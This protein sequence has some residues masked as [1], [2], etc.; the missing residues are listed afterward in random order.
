MLF[1]NVAIKLIG[2]GCSLRPMLKSSLSKFW[3]RFHHYFLFI[4]ALLNV[5]CDGQHMGYHF[6]SCSLSYKNT[7]RNPVHLHCRV[8]ALL[9]ACNFRLTRGLVSGKLAISDYCYIWS[10]KS[11]LAHHHS[12]EWNFRKRIYSVG[13]NLV[14]V[15]SI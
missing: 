9:T 5:H 2:I 14:I 13:Y 10:L 15:K 4:L 6:H 3:H 7:I 12:F 1:C 11:A 8:C